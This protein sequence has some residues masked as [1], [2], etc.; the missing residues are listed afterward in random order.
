MAETTG[1]LTAARI[2]SGLRYELS[3]CS[4]ITSPSALA[5][6]AAMSPIRKSRMR[7]GPVGMSGTAAASMIRNVSPLRLCSKSVAICTSPRRATSVR[8]ISRTES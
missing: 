5:P 8:S 6:T 1:T 3:S 2:S 7:L 4:A